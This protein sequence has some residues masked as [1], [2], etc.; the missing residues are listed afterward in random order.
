MARLSPQWLQADS[1]P[2]A[3]DRQLIT[4][5]WPAAASKGCAVSA[6]SGMAVNVAGGQVAVPASDGTTVLCTS[7]AVEVVTLDPAPASGT[8]RI[9]LVICQARSTEFGGTNEDFVFAK[10]NGA[11]A[12]SPVAPAVPVNA[13]ALAQV[14]VPGG[15][16]NVT[17]ANITD[18]RGPSTAAD[19]TIA[20]RMYPTGQ[21]VLANGTLGQ[22]LNMTTEYMLGGFALVNNSL[23]VP[24]DGIYFCTA[25]LGWQS[26][27]NPVGAGQFQLRMAVNG[28]TA[29]IIGGPVQLTVTS[30][31]VT[32]G[33][34]TFPLNRG[35]AV[36]LYGYQAT[37]AGA[38]TFADSSMSWLD[39]VRI[40]PRI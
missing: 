26:A 11:Q 8:N 12:S 17:A 23:I 27:G 15:S 16:A 2:G 32:G 18:L 5:L 34:A 14:Y 7:T 10:V 25:S 28:N 31:G 40:G 39:L 30:Y 13:V 36:A 4:A 35:A 19:K 37:G 21:T 22:V 24:A 20:A 33:A 9:D 1:Y 29:R 38:G 6:G 3:A